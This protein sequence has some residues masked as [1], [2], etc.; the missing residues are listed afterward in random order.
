MKISPYFKIEKM[1]EKTEAY[2]NTLN[3]FDSLPVDSK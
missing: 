3:L 2:W 1:W